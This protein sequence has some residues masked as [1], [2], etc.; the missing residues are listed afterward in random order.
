MMKRYM[1]NYLVVIFSIYAFT[2]SLQLMKFRLRP[3]GALNLNAQEPLIGDL[4]SSSESN[5]M[6]VQSSKTSDLLDGIFT[7]LQ[8]LPNES[9]DSLIR[10][11][12]EKGRRALATMRRPTN[13]DE[14]WK[15]TNVKSLF[16]PIDVLKSRNSDVVMPSKEVI[17]QYV[18]EECSHTCFVFVDG[19][20]D[21]GLSSISKVDESC[22]EVLHFSAS[23]DSG[24]NRGLPTGAMP[25]FLN[26]DLAV[27]YSPDTNEVKRNSFG[28]DVLSS[29]NMAACNEM[30]VLRVKSGKDHPLPVQI[31]N[32]A[33]SLCNLVSPRVLV[34]LEKDSKLKLK[35]SVAG[36]AEISENS[37]STVVNSNTRIFV[38]EG[39][40]LEHLYVQ[41]LSTAS[42][43]ME[44]VASEVKG[45]GT[46]DLSVLQMGAT[47]SRLNVHINLGSPGSNCSLGVVALSNKDQTM[48]LHSSIVHDA[49][50]ARS[51][52]Q[53]RNVI[54]DKGEVIF[55]GR[56]RIPAHAQLTES[57]QLC[58]TL[59]LGKR[60]RVIAMPTLEITADNVVCSH[61]ASVADLDEN[62][63]FY[64][65]A[66][67]IDRKEVPLFLPLC[68]FVNTFILIFMIAGEEAFV[69]RICV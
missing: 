25:V 18:D 8:N 21:A 55:K 10:S 50:S 38:E 35:Q 60:A 6:S 5:A 23:R 2:E 24:F 67:G 42:R 33:S 63:M 61:G 16:G 30:A 45:N 51:R 58:R 15:Y 57:D 29:L 64:L 59:M 17:S 56:I 3:Q 20:Y 41:E 11:V 27:A 36:G 4:S 19:K 12:R 40:T 1:I 7:S 69:D 47:V 43:H 46:H 28:S 53:Q 34:V 39:A 26:D 62:S 31:L 48:D 44:V 49:E 32:F 65:S 14:A 54:G 52:Q 22:L 9:E 13:R 37:G 66:R 68:L